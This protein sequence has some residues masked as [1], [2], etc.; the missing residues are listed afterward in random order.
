MSEAKKNDTLKTIRV[1]VNVMGAILV[2]IE[3]VDYLLEY[4]QKEKN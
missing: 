3:A 4:L 1:V 2:L